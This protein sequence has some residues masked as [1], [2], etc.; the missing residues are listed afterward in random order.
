MIAT[1]VQTTAP[2]SA[3]A[4]SRSEMPEVSDVP[5][6]EMVHPVPGF[7]EHRRFALVQLDGDGVL[8]SL[9]S[10][11]D[12][13]LRFLVVPPFDFWPD[14]TPVIGDDVVADLGIEAVGD[15][16]VL[17]VLTAGATLA[18]TTANLLAP[19]VLNTAT[20]RAAQVILDD[21]ALPVAA[22]LP[23]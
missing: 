2:A 8:C 3:A 11:D 17:V 10:L 6:I 7:P 12:E 20:R 16:L 19:V 15:V 9:R 18:D 5:V 21:P 13:S 22:P 4:G 23:V 1:M 14:Y